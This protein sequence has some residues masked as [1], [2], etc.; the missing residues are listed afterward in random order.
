VKRKRLK[1]A[2]TAALARKPWGSPPELVEEHLRVAY[3]ALGSARPEAALLI[4]KVADLEAEAVERSYREACARYHP[5]RYLGSNQAVRAL[6]E[7]CFARIS[8]AYHLLKDP[9]QFQQAKE[10]LEF[11]ETGKRPVNQKSRARARV[12]F[13]RAEMMF[14]QHRFDDAVKA[15]RRAEEGDP[16]RWEYRYLRLRG[17]WHAGTEQ[18]EDVVTGI[19]EME[20][21]DSTDRGEALYIAGEMLLKDGRKKEAF[22]LFKQAVAIDPE[23]VGAR[24]RIRLELSRRTGVSDKPGDSRKQGDAKKAGRPL[25]GGL[26]RRRGE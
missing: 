11:R 20:E 12:D 5:D 18:T 23:N 6:A 26:F 10:R 9:T 13:K 14:R 24:R 19:L 15:A 16:S 25:F 2:R 7:G 22:G 8:E 17:A 21:M 3:E 1:T 4:R